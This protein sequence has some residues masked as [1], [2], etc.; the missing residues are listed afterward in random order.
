MAI[1]GKS[2]TLQGN[3]IDIR[4]ALTALLATSPQ[5][6][7]IVIKSFG[8]N[9]K[10]KQITAVS[11][12]VASTTYALNAQ[13]SLVVN[14]VTTLFSCIVPNDDATFTA[15][16]WVN[17]GPLN[18]GNVIPSNVYILTI[19]FVTGGTADTAINIYEGDPLTVENQLKADA[20]SVTTD[21]AT[22]SDYLSIGDGQYGLAGDATN[23]LRAG[24]GSMV[25][26]DWYV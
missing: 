16:K 10:Y 26:V 21:I 9:P 12:W 13:V 15:A 20:E 11:A 5:I 4:T 25:A 1:A 8:F 3:L 7:S 24:N 19:A 18:A 2:T 22:A 23:P 6:F 17:L 14:G